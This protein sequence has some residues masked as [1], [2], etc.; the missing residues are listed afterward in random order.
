ME[1][2]NNLSLVPEPRPH[3]PFVAPDL[4]AAAFVRETGQTGCVF[5]LTPGLYLRVCAFGKRA[6]A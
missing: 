2:P 6:G 1:R 5:A 4:W 3:L